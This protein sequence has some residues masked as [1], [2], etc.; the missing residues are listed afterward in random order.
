MI[1][2]LIA[3]LAIVLGS[4]AA[5]LEIRFEPA[6]G[7]IAQAK[8]SYD[9]NAERD[10]LVLAND[11]RAQAGLAPLQADAGLTEAAR[12]HAQLMAEQGRL[13]HQFSGEPSLLQ[14]ITAE[15]DLHMDR[16]GENVAYAA[17]VQQAQDTLMH[18][19]PHRE[20]L[21]SADFNAA[22]FGVVRSGST[23]YI[24]QDFARQLPIVSA[25]K[26][27]ESV[28]RQVN[29]AR[30]DAGTSPLQRVQSAA[31]QAGSCPAKQPSLVKAS[32]ARPRYILRYTSMEPGSLPAGT[33]KTTADRSLRAFAVEACYARN[34]SY[35]NGAYW[36]VVQFF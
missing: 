4:G 32:A 20:N 10:L 3:S 27:E 22:G 1:R 8:A 33:E 28:A 5:P 35:P 34:S 15:S 11:A 36:V 19:P 21:L 13:S 17:N 18:S 31:A 9:P 2:A 30:I 29:R 23:I 24:T 14:R 7:P 26:A 25:D 16:S 6:A 12:A